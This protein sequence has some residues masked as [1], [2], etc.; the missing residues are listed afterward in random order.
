MRVLSMNKFE[1]Y[2]PIFTDHFLLDWLTM[3]KVKDVFELRNDAV[4]AEQSGRQI[5]QSIEE[6]TKYVN[7]MMRLVM[8]NEA[9]IWGISTKEN[10]DFLGI[11]CIWN[12]DRDEKSVS[13]RFEI[14]RDQQR[15]GVMQEVLT[16]MTIFCFEELGLRKIKATLL[17]DNV[18]TSSLLDRAGFSVDSARTTDETITYELTQN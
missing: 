6:T 12:F 4:I 13:I 15:K 16:R 8:N 1:L 11:F 18:A 7:N 14:L 10:R 3:S 17:K 9:L 5:D 2:H